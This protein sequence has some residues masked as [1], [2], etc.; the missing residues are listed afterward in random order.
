[1]LNNVSFNV[2][3]LFLRF[4][5]NAG[6][7]ASAVH[8]YR[9]LGPVPGPGK[10]VARGAIIRRLPVVVGEGRRQCVIR[11]AGALPAVADETIRPP[12]HQEACELLIFDRVITWFA[13]SQPWTQ[14]QSSLARIIKKIL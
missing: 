10:V 4:R 12:R 7:E 11:V 8:A 1:M 2:L 3:F 14:K 5:C 6:R 9:G 13:A